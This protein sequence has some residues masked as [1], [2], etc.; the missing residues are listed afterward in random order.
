M[1]EIRASRWLCALLAT[2]LGGG[3]L[4]A[5]PTPAPSQL[6][7]RFLLVISTQWDYP[8]SYV[9]EGGS[10]FSVVAALL[11]TWGIPFEILRL[12]QQRTGCVPPV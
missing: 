4:A 1:N 6:P 9:I 3:A 7:Y 11:K 12:D 10:E 8:N 2:L 5:Q